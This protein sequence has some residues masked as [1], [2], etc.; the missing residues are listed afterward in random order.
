MFTEAKQIRGA[1]GVSGWCV[2]GEGGCHARMGAAGPSPL[3]D[4]P[5][6]QAPSPTPA[7]V[8][9]RRPSPL[10]E[11]KKKK[12]SPFG[13]LKANPLY[14][15]VSG[16]LERVVT[17]SRKGCGNGSVLRASD[18]DGGFSTWNGSSRQQTVVKSQSA[19]TLPV[20]PAY[21]PRRP[22]SWAQPQST[23]S[24][25][26]QSPSD[27][28]YRSLPPTDYRLK[29]GGFS[30]LPPR[31]GGPRP[32]RPSPTFH[33]TPFRVS[34]SS[35]KNLD[36]KLALLFDILDTQERFAKVN[37]EEMFYLETLRLGSIY[38]FINFLISSQFMILKLTLSTVSLHS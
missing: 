2:R 32:P 18:D 38:I 19:Y 7:A 26:A 21:K 28:G 33:G 25:P 20:P 22:H 36:D 16:R 10:M 12:S 15:S 14:R 29:G 6:E 5:Q 34:T 17:S 23:V 35:F 1:G 27:S 37:T 13:F 8:S 9:I 24:L 4:V 11:Q 3:R 30:S 31:R